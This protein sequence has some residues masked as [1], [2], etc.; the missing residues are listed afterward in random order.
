MFKTMV[1][2]SGFR[3]RMP[4]GHH[5]DTSPGAGGAIVKINH[6]PTTRMLADLF[7]KNLN[8]VLFERFTSHVTGNA[9]VSG[10]TK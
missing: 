10:L 8:H 1:N 9:E 5:I 3:V 6:C 2:W 7:T 4:N